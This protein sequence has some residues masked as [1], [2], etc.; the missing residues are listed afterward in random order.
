MKMTMGFQ[1]CLN[2]LR[3][4]LLFMKVWVRSL[5]S[6]SGLRIRCFCE[7]RCRSHSSDLVLLWLWP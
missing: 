6:I 5:A 2:G 1:L 3:S 7:L 4:Q